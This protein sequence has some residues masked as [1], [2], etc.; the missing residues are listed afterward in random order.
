MKLPNQSAPVM[1]Y[2][3]GNLTILSQGAMAENQMATFKRSTTV[4]SN[5]NNISPSAWCIGA[6]VQNGRV[7]VTLPVVGERCITLP[8]SLPNFT[9]IRA[10]ISACTHYWVPTGACVSL[11]GPGGLNFRRCFGWC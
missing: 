11:T 8:I 10:C 7:C 6:R 2:T 9:L 1:R 3:T 5:V 4:Y